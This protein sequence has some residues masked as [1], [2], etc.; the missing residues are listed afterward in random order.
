M[1]LRLL[2]PLKSML[3]NTDGVSKGQRTLLIGL[4]LL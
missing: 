3:S 2:P 4:F 1:V